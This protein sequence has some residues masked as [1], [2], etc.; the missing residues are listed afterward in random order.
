M[1]IADAVNAVEQKPKSS[2]VLLSCPG[3][4]RPSIAKLTMPL[5]YLHSVCG[6]FNTDTI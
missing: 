1:I 4:C 6:K 3:L 2:S 5:P